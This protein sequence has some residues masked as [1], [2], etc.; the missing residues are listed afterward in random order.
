ME[1]WNFGTMGL[2]KPVFKPHNISYV[3]AQYSSIP[4]GSK[5]IA[6]KNT[7]IPINCI[8]SEPFNYAFNRF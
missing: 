5:R 2:K 4:C 7:V 3:H 1:C 8:N 6:A